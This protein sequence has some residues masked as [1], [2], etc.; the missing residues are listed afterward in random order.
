MLLVCQ[1]VEFKNKINKYWYLKN[2]WHL[3]KKGWDSN[4]IIWDNKLRRTIFIFRKNF[5]IIKVWYKHCFKNTISYFEK[6]R[7]KFLEIKVFL[8]N[9]YLY[10][11]YFY[12]LMSWVD[13]EKRVFNCNSWPKRENLYN[14]Y[15]KSCQLWPTHLFFSNKLILEFWR[16]TLSSIPYQISIINL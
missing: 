2:W 1:I 11:N 14:S 5:F 9:L 8:K 4:Y 3:S 15:S 6:C 7:G 16:L 12:Y 13:R 10:K